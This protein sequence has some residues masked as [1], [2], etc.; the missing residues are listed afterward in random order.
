M[1]FIETRDLNLDA[2]ELRLGLPGTAEES[3]KQ[4]PPPPPPLAR[5]NKRAL[6]DMND[7]QPGPCKDKSH[8]SDAKKS[9]PPTK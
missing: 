9:A 8:I 3:Q 2:T 6:P 4:T 1:A 5:S 7:D